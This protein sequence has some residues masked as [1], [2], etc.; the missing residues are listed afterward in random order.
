M[1]DD[2]KNI[3]RQCLGCAKRSVKCVGLGG[4]MC[5]RIFVVYG[6]I[7]GGAES[8]GAGGR[9]RGV[10]VLCRVAFDEGTSVLV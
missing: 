5:S 9:G 3:R 4:S 1:G 10:A 2:K 6:L 8:R 7:S